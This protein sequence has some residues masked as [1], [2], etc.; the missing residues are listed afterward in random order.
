MQSNRKS[1]PPQTLQALAR[2]LVDGGDR[3][4][5]VSFHGETISRRSFRELATEVNS[6]ACMLAAKGIG[7]DEPV[8]LCGPGSPDW[9]IACLAILR[10]SACA[11]P[12]DSQLATDTLRYVIKDSG[13]RFALVAPS[14]QKRLRAL[15]AEAGV[16]VLPLAGD[17]RA[18]DSGA[19]DFPTADPGVAPFC[20]IPPAPRGH[21][22][23]CR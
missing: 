18:H 1:G 20:S 22:R 2:D 6:R 12:V 23:A 3:D 8:I 13:A 21:L 10:C 15:F 5:L 9:I 16:E 14:A 4:A 19:R 11:V 17:G 7:A